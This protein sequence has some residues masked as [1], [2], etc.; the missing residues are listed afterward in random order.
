V[1]PR[2]SFRLGLEALAGRFQPAYSS[3]HAL[4]LPSD[5]SGDLDPVPPHDEHLRAM[6]TIRPPYCSCGAS[7]ISHLR[8]LQRSQGSR[9][10]TGFGLRRRLISRP[11]SSGKR[12][13]RRRC[14][15]RYAR[16]PYM[17]D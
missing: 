17:S 13:T 5:T 16:N 6:L 9:L 12:W 15:A 8:P 3:P 14:S 2:P 4:A 11:R 7:E 1:Y 10:T